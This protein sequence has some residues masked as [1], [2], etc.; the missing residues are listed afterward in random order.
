[1]SPNPD[2]YLSPGTLI[3]PYRIERFIGAGPDAFNYRAQDAASGR[4]VLIKELFP[5]GAAKREAD[6]R[7]VAASAEAHRAP[8][9]EGIA[10]LRQLAKAWKPFRHVNVVPVLDGID[11]NGTYYL[12]LDRVDGKSLAELLGDG[13]P[14]TPEEL[15]EILP[16]LLAGI[17]AIHD[18]GLLHLDLAPESLILRRDGLLAIGRAHTLR[19]RLGDA[20]AD[21]GDSYRAEEL[22]AGTDVGAASDIYGLAA[23]LFRLVTGKP[24]SSAAARR[25]TVGAG[26]HDA[27][28]QALEAQIGI[29]PSPLL[30]AIRHGLAL[31]AAMRPQNLTAMKAALG[32]ATAVDIPTIPLRDRRG[33]TRPVTPRADDGEIA[34]VR[35]QREIQKPAAD[36]A[37]APDRKASASDDEPATV[38]TGRSAVARAPGGRDTPG[39]RPVNLSGAAQP[40]DVPTVRHPR[41]KPVLRAP[42][43][44]PPHPDKRKTVIYRKG[45]AQL[46]TAPPKLERAATAA[47]GE[48]PPL[49]ARFTVY[50]PMTLPPGRWLDLLIFI[51]EPGI[52]SLVRQ[53]YEARL[54]GRNVALNAPR[55]KARFAVKPGG[56][57]TVVPYFPGCRI[58]PPR[59]TLEWWE[60]FHCFEFRLRASREVAGF[61]EGPGAGAIAFYLGP[62]LIGEMRI[63]F[64]IADEAIEPVSNTIAAA[65]DSFDAVFPAYAP[66]DEIG[67]RLAAAGE[68]FD[69]PF[70]S[71]L[72]KMRTGDWD[73]EVLKRIEAAERFQLFWSAAAARSPQLEEEWKFALELGR[74]N[75]MSASYWRHPAPGLPLPLEDVPLRHLALPLE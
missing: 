2:S 75:F 44:P 71:E 64:T 67:D 17:V 62:L 36:A 58:N 55:A 23:T 19:K 28:G 45:K 21:A 40:D 29:W 20:P 69:N 26:M 27:V 30:A 49:P 14:L 5:R 73:R 4:R 60:N 7:G 22:A 10:E 41:S 70:F 53:D 9:A 63:A 61:V 46:I 43:P 35:Y 37:I 74:E 34:T 8:L 33:K 56:A 16:A 47:E 42:A 65:A 54:E 3:G 18:S 25:K 52:D 31:G 50:Q 6:G 13:E 66:Q 12:A 48:P 57:V 51:H 32:A 68:K 11:A 59:A 38:W 1:M 39:R 24:P 72:L 15:E